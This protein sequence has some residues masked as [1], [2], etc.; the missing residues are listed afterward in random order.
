MVFVKK[1][2]THAILDVISKINY[3]VNQKK[4]TGLLFT[5]KVGSLWYPWSSK[6]LVGFSIF[7]YCS[8]T[9]IVEYGVPRG[10]NLGPILFYVNDIFL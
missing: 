5:A 6:S 2:F 10:S 8:S 3:N 4:L 1:M 7:E 9:K